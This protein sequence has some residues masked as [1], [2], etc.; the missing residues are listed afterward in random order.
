MRVPPLPLPVGDYAEIQMI[1]SHSLTRSLRHA[2]AFLS[3]SLSLSAVH[4][5]GEKMVGLSC[6]NLLLGTADVSLYL[7]PMY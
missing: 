1:V 6:E 3:L 7:S 2:P 5:A 4:T